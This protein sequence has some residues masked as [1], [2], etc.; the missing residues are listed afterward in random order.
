MKSKKGANIRRWE[1]EKNCNFDGSPVGPCSKL[2]TVEQLFSTYNVGPSQTTEN[3]QTN[4]EK[5]AVKDCTPPGGHQQE[6][7]TK[8][9]RR[10]NVKS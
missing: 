8:N 5:V 1:G 3:G 6:K 9:E 10:S 2:A 7:L 4:I